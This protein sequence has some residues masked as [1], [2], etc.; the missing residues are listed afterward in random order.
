MGRVLANGSESKEAVAPVLSRGQDHR[1]G[2]LTANF[3]CPRSVPLLAIWVGR[4]FPQTVEPIYQNLSIL[5][6]RLRSIRLH[7]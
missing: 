1:M 5:I 7:F 2:S 3:T 4:S 6:R